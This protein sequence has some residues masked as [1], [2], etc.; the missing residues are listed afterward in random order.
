MKIETIRY[1]YDATGVPADA[2][3]KFGV[4]SDYVICYYIKN[5]EKIIL[6][7]IDKVARSKKYI[8]KG[9]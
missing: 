8:A 9:L 2:T 7:S 5:K 3:L 4:E 1:I 6:P